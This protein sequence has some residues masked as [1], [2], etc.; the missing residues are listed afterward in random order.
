[1]P[2]VLGFYTPH[3]S[4]MMHG[5]LP[6]GQG[7]VPRWAILF[8]G[9]A[10][11]VVLGGAP[12]WADMADPDSISIEVVYANRNLMETGDSLY[13]AHYN[14]AY[15][16]IPDDD[17]DQTFIFR[18]FDTDQTTLL[19][20]A[21]AYPYVDNGY[22]QGVVSFYF[23]AA[24]APTW[25]GEY[26]IRISGN[27]AFFSDPP[28]EDFQIQTSDYTNLTGQDANRSQV[29]DRV[30]SIAE[31][32]E[33]AWDVT[34]LDEQDMGIVLSS[35]GE[36]Y[37]RNSV[38]GL[39]AIAPELFF[40]QTVEVDYTERSWNTSQ[41]DTYRDRFGLGDF[42]GKG[43][44]AGAHLFRMDTQLF[45]SGIILIV[46]FGLMGYS[47]RQ[48]KTSHPG[49]VAAIIVTL[50][51]AVMGWL[52]MVILAVIGLLCLIYVGYFWF[53]QKA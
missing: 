43:V 10:L 6:S 40:L 53:L 36:A 29:G 38:N 32:L 7:R 28:S 8:V 52:N 23:D 47:K 41:A 37:F 27:P 49:F 3:T 14:V 26:F 39:Q 13:I 35:N 4:Q 42:L 5:A 46:I 19:G 25:E 15:T 18:L 12:A 50:G 21:V 16:S 17:I 33:V 34:L 2:T 44:G 1:M 20:S 31:D 22:G 24:D 30:V 9:L 48:F 45:S 11:L 51:G